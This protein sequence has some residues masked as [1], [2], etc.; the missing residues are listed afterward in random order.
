[1]NFNSAVKNLF[2]RVDTASYRFGINIKESGIY[3]LNKKFE[4]NKK[5]YSLSWFIPGPG[6]YRAMRNC[7]Q[8]KKIRDAIFNDQI[9]YAPED[10]DE[11]EYLIRVRKHPRWGSP[12]YTLAIRLI[13]LTFLIRTSQIHPPYSYGFFGV[14]L[15]SQVVASVLVKGI[16]DKAIRDIIKYTSQDKNWQALN[17]KTESV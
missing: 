6:F 12:L 17:S 4:L 3:R 10:K 2:E 9:H 7:W 13:G 16:N 11:S 14:F 1:M 8:R 15:A 5:L